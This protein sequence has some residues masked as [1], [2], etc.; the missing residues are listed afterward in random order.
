MA[1]VMLRTPLALDLPAP[2]ATAHGRRVRARRA[3]V[4]T[5]AHAETR[6]GGFVP[7]TI[8]KNAL[9]SP[10]GA[11][12]VAKEFPE[13]ETSASAR[14]LG[15]L[16]LSAFPVLGM[17]AA[18]EAA[19]A[20]VSPVASAFAAYGH[21]LGLV[22]VVASLTVEKMLVKPNP[23]EEDAKKLVIA[24]SVYGIAGVLVLYTGYLRVTQ[25]GKGWEYYSHEPIFWVKMG[26][27]AVMGS[28]SLF[29]TTKI[30]QMAA[31]QSK[32]GKPEISE[33][34]A[35]RMQKIINGE[36]LAVGSIPLAAALMARGVAFSE[37]MPWQAGAAPVALVSL[38]LSVKY[39]KEAL[40]W[41]EDVVESE[42]VE[43]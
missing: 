19:E 10:V 24:D 15:M 9:Q 26:L 42:K 21:Y 30:I 14:S 7:R 2:R 29:C 41:T 38:A 6:T 39:V 25:Y 22:L 33:K 1:A 37:G 8:Q 20:A 28:S 36:L 3:V 11:G 13:G 4:A 5:A 12:L 17:L 40:T 32:G 23:S 35:A 43:A 27:F 16:S 34:L 31:A 18:P